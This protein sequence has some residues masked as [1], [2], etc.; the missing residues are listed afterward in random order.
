MYPP[1]SPNL[2]HNPI[3]SGLNSTKHMSPMLNN[4]ANFAGFNYGQSY[5]QNLSSN[6]QSS[7]KSIE[8]VNASKLHNLEINYTNHAS[9]RGPNKEND[10]ICILPKRLGYINDELA[11][12]NAS[13]EQ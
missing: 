9:N 6:F 12:K 4:T 1:Q 13:F 5:N 10:S 7:N 8:E 3:T 11:A 2:F